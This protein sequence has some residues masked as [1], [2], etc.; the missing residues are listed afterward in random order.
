MYRVSFTNRYHSQKK[1]NKS[2][3]LQ[4]YKAC[5]CKRIKKEF[6]LYNSNI[7]IDLNNE[8]VTSNFNLKKSLVRN[9]ENLAQITAVFLP[10]LRLNL[11][12]YQSVIE[13]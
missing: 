7:F 9:F 11:I 13:S 6:F 1:I 12:N 10:I 8:T 2:I 4:L 5:Y 3:Y